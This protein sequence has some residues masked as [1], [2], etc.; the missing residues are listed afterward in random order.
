MNDARYDRVAVT[1]HWLM[2][3]AVIGQLVFGLMLDDLAPR[4][5]PARAGVINLHKSI[6]IVLGLL[7]L[8]RLAWRWTHQPPAWPASLSPAQQRAARWGHGL[9]YA[10]MI[11]APL[12]GVIASNFSKHGVRFFGF[13]LAPLGPDLVPVYKFFSGLHG[14]LVWTLMVLVAGHVLM[15][16][17]HAWIDRNG[18]FSRIK[19]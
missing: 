12:A 3:L 13:K 1:L 10:C 17:K 16:L 9:L 18:L 4:G 2:A 19:F 6:G 7:A 5:T 14:L 11:L 8:A 15:A